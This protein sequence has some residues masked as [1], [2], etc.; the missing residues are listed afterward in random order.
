MKQA[1]SR[2]FCFISA[3]ILFLTVVVIC[4]PLDAD[5]RARSGGRSFGGGG[6][7]GTF[8]KPSSPST[9]PAVPPSTPAGSPLGQSGGSS[10]M[11]G[12]GGG[13]LGGMIGGMLF[14]SPGHGMGM[15][16]VGGSG[17]GLIELLLLGGLGFFLYKRFIKPNRPAAGGQAASLFSG[18]RPSGNVPGFSP[19]PMA[20][21]DSVEDG[22]RQ[23]RLSEPDFDPERFVEIAQDVFFR[24]QAAWMRRDLEPV[25]GLIGDRLLAEYE[26]HL[27]EMK[28]K[29]LLNRLENIA[30]RQAAI[31]EAG[32]ENSEVFVTVHF[33]ANLLDYTVKE[34]TGEIVEGDNTA[35]V[36]FEEKWIFARPLYTTAW[37]LE[38]VQ[39]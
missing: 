34:S 28:Q 22:I 6:S 12:L 30:V 27:A 7:S 8:S 18:A 13:L 9:R 38:G 11:R 20:P 1:Y 4:Y 26:S 2:T 19:P 15:G 25:R 24:I 35:P 21:Q 23:I 36:K 14:S 10:F 17:I 31:V 16:G 37:K 3:A 32:T 39:A 33:V 5:A 29:G